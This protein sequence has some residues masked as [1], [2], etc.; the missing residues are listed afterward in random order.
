MKHHYFDSKCLTALI[1]AKQKKRSLREISREIG[2]VSPS[3]LSRI[4]KGEMPDIYTLMWLC[5]WLEISPNE[6]IREASNESNTISPFSEVIVKLH[7]IKELDERF[8]NALLELIYVM[9]EK[10]RTPS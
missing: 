2:D 8:I 4:G 6:I 9:V 10:Y 3:T 5:D 7:Q 1:K